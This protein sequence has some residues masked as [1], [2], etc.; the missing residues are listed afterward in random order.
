MEKI[1]PKE[2]IKYPQIADELIKMANEDQRMRKSPGWDEE[3]DKRNTARLREIIE[4]IG[5]PTKSKVGAEAS[6][7]AWLLAQHAD[8]EVEFQETC[9]RLMRKTGEGEVEKADLAYLTDRVLVNNK[10]HQLFGTQCH[11]DD[12]GFISP[13]EFEGTL[14]EVNKRR[15]EAGIL[16]T[17]EE[18]INRLQERDDADLLFSNPAQKF[19]KIMKEDPEATFWWEDLEQRIQT[20]E[21]LSGMFMLGN[22]ND[23]KILEGTEEGKLRLT[24]KGRG[25]LKR[26][27]NSVKDEID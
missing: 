8:D 23:R 13:R 24:K 5:W 27:I 9:L 15:K 17:V 7:F 22:L 10:K 25:Y 21:K 6:H 2:K 16:S 19:W 1:E 14:E 20:D 11:T 18:S 3:V 26:F 4:E 12:K